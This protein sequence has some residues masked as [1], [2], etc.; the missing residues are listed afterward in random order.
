MLLLFKGAT[1]NPEPKPV[2]NV[3][4]NGSKI[5]RNNFSDNLFSKN[6]IDNNVVNSIDGANAL[7]LD[8]SYE[9]KNI[10]DQNALID[11]FE[12]KEEKKF[13]KKIFQT[14]KLSM[15]YHLDY[16]LK[17]HHISKIIMRQN[18]RSYFRRKII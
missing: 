5:R 9:I 10:Q 4:I 17:V 15:N 13:L 1:I 14:S 2:F 6:N 11:S 16:Q 8:E 3:V 18:I 12:N 7:K